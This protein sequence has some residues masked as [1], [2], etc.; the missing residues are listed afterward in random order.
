[1]ATSGGWRDIYQTRPQLPK[2]PFSRTPSPNG[3]LT[4]FAAEA[5]THAR[6]RRTFANAFSDKALREQAPITES[7]ASRLITW[8]RP[9][10]FK[11]EK[12]KE[13]DIA[14]Y[15]GFATLDIMRELS[16]GDSFHSLDAGKEHS[17]VLNSFLP[18]KFGSVR[19][20][21][22]LSYPLDYIF[23]WIFLRLTSRIRER[24]WA[25]GTGMVSRRLE[26]GDLGP[27]KSDL[28]SPII[29]NVNE[30]K[31]KGITRGELDV[32]AI[33]LLLA[34]NPLS[35]VAIAA[36]TY[37]LHMYPQT[38]TVF[39]AEIRNRFESENEITVS[40]THDLSYFDAVLMETLRM[41]HPTPSDP[42]PRMIV[43]AGQHVEGQWISGGV[44]CFYKIFC[45]FI[46]GKNNNRYLQSILIRGIL[47]PL[48]NHNFFFLL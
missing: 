9:D 39:N 24:N 13:I 41:H 33:G 46:F 40:S 31:K 10:I 14:K 38:M 4:L 34:G 21:L 23:G 8:L 35:T 43:P 48:P 25:T 29:R 19:T 44:S 42:K 45:F 37:F 6:L 7:H 36:A 12:Q 18:V 47:I 15:Y 16:L 2:D 28:L 32:N 20:S 5:D 11:E 26:F 3:T 17:W 27:R 22:S 30:E 1:M